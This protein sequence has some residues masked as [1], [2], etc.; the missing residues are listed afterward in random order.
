MTLDSVN[1]ITLDAAAF[2]SG[3]ACPAVGLSIVV[4]NPALL[5]E[6]FANRCDVYLKRIESNHGA[7]IPGARRAANRRRAQTQGL[8]VATAVI[9]QLE[10]FA[11]L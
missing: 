3:P 1:N 6:N 11:D 8:N 9:E 4:M 10:Q 7:Y 5:H 2:N